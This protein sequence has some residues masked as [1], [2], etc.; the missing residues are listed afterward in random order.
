MKTTISPRMEAV[1][2][3]IVFYEEIKD[4]CSKPDKSIT[5]ESLEIYKELADWGFVEKY[6]ISDLS[7]KWLYVVVIAMHLCKQIDNVKTS[8][9]FS[10][11]DQKGKWEIIQTALSKA[12]KLSDKKNK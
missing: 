1:D 2:K 3:A 7:N 10:Q 11:Q 12:G 6:S 9:S 8:D 5:G 4:A